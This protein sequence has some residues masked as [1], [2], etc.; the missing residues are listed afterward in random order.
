MHKRHTHRQSNT[1]S[2]RRARAHTHTHTHTH[3][4][5][6]SHAHTHVHT[7]K[8]THHT[9]PTHARTLARTLARTHAHTH[10]RMHAHTHTHTHTLTLEEFLPWLSET[11][12]IEGYKN[13]PTQGVRAGGEGKGKW[14]PRYGDQM[15][16]WSCL[17][18][19]V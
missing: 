2:Q 17:S 19:P 1:D 6:L 7:L 16:T 4:H 10:A 13:R 3:T 9:P 18:C 15:E 11:T 14:V 5:S 12:E 8:R